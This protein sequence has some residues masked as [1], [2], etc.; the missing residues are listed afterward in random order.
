MSHLDFGN[1]KHLIVIIIVICI[2]FVGE[3]QGFTILLVLGLPRN[4]GFFHP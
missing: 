1:I 2:D 4:Y 3:Y